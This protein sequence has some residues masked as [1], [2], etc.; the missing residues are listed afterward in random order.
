MQHDVE[1]L[2]GTKLKTCHF[3]GE[4]CGRTADQDELI[5]MRGEPAPKDIQASHHGKCSSSS[6]SA[7]CTRSSASL[8]RLRISDSGSTSAVS[9]TKDGL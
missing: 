5:P 9:G 7:C 4:G 1:I 3:E 2:R 8:C 6:A